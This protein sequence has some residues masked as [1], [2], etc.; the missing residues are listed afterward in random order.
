MALRAVDAERRRALGAPL[1]F[2]WAAGFVVGDATSPDDLAVPTRRE[3]VPH[4]FTTGDELLA[5]V[6]RAASP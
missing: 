1:L 2:G 6:Q 3:R 4:V 5:P